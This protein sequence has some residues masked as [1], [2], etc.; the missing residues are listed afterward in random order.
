MP[1]HSLSSS[2]CAL[3]LF[4]L[5]ES[6]L[7]FKQG[8]NNMATST[9]KPVHVFRCGGISASIWQNV[10]AYGLYF[11]VTFS[12]PVKDQ[13]GEWHNFRA[14]TLRDLDAIAFPNAQAKEW[15]AANARQSA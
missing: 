10:G 12:R 11:T 14:F 9:Q 7:H 15:I 6:Q 8:G 1:G 13:A 3:A 4:H 2:K 5:C